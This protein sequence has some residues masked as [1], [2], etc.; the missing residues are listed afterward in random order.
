LHDVLLAH[1]F[2]LD[3]FDIITWHCWEG[4]TKH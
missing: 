2:E 1:K 4:Y 3:S